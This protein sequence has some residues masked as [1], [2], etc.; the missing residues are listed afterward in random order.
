MSAQRLTVTQAD[1]MSA[2]A[3]AVAEGQS[4]DAW[5]DREGLEPGALAAAAAFLSHTYLEA[6][7]GVPASL[8][9]AF[10]IGWD[11]HRHFRGELDG[12]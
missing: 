7:A 1:M 6:N 4:V 8:L 10:S 9:A 3:E 12:G 5:L 2:L 11:C